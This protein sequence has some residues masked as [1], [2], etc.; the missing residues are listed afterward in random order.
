MPGSSGGRPMHSPIELLEAAI[1]DLEAAIEFRP[2]EPGSSHTVV[3]VNGLEAPGA[4]TALGR[5]LVGALASAVGLDAKLSDQLL[6]RGVKGRQEVTRTVN[7]LIRDT[8]DFSADV[9]F[10]D[11]KRNAWIGEGLGHVLLALSARNPT[12]C[13]DGQVRTLSAI[14]PTAT[15][16]GL[17]SVGLYVQGG[18]LGMAIG[19]SKSTMAHA[20]A[21]LGDAIGLFVKIEKGDYEQDL[22]QALSVFRW[23]LSAD[24]KDQLKDTLWNENASYLPMIV[25]RDAYNFANHRP[26]MAKLFQP[27][28]RRRIIVVQLNDFHEFFDSVADAMRASITE[29]VI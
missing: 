3:A 25:Y 4:A 27:L 22:R 6:A 13:V 28:E 12:S 10:R 24:L 15:R 16:Q 5:Y 9:L 18:V 11:T 21:N 14:H 7:S 29:L 20:D 2:G 17:D 23:V 26:N 19:E 1:Q 8:N